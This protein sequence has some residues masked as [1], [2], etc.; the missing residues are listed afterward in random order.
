MND[1]T[2]LGSMYN[3]PNTVV[4]DAGHLVSLAVITRPR[5]MTPAKP[6]SDHVP[7]ALWPSDNAFGIPL[8]DIERQADIVELPV[9]TWGSRRRRN[10]AGTIHFYTEDY[11]FSAVWRFPERVLDTGARCIIEPNFSVYANCPAAV[12]IHRTY[13]KRWLARYWQHHGARVAVDLNV[14]PDYY[15]INMMGVPKGWAAYATRGY[16]DRLDYLERE[17][18]IAQAHAGGPVSLLVYGGGNAVTDFCRQRAALGVVH[19]TELMTARRR[20]Q[21]K[22]DG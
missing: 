19:V 3:S 10:G 8:L 9:E 16:S 14:H 13:Q 1:S 4:T 7:D 21:Y 2:Y 12:A 22:D 15:A 18:E 6:L 11:R 17:L 20:A 5:P